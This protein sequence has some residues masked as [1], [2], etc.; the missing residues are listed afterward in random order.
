MTNLIPTVLIMLAL[1]FLTEKLGKRKVFAAGLVVAVIGLVGFGISAPSITQMLIFNV[2]YGLGNGLHKGMIVA[3]TADMV[4]YTE[5]TTGQFMP[6]AGNAGI[7]ATDKL[8]SGLGSVLFG[9][10]LSAAGFN[11]ALDSQ[12][13]GQPAAVITAISVMFIWVPAVLL[14]AALVIFTIFFGFEKE[15]TE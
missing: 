6:G 8:G 5:K 3:L 7:S 11:A 4:I 12:A 10:A 15:V 1:P 14:I 13:I 2:L 9:F